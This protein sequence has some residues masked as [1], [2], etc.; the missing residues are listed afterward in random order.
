[1]CARA[2]RT[3]HC[4][5]SSPQTVRLSA[6]SPQ[7]AR[8]PRPPARRAPHKKQP[9]PS[10]AAPACTLS[11]TCSPAP[12]PTCAA[13]QD[14]MLN[15]HPRINHPSGLTTRARGNT[16]YLRS[17]GPP[18]FT[19]QGS[20]RM[21]NRALPLN[22]RVVKTLSQFKILLEAI[23]SA[24]PA[25]LTWHAFF[26]EAS[27]PVAVLSSF[28]G[29]YT[30]RQPPNCTTGCLINRTPVVLADK[31]PTRDPHRPR[32]P[33][34]RCGHSPDSGP[35]AVWRRH[36]CVHGERRGEASGCSQPPSHTQRNAESGTADKKKSRRK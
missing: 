14:P 2:H 18:H 4:P 8:L 34:R 7:L 36:G 20:P 3:P 26:A 5:P 31:H 28:Q 17:C 32:C 15:L 33:S 24:L 21:R 29:A 30:G 23:Q 13:P 10:T 16:G 27:A 9:R 22:L 6:P 25:L 11:A 1:M 12:A 19:T 35:G